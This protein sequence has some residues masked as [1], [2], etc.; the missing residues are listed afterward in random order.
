MKSVIKFAPEEIAFSRGEILRSRGVPDE[1]QFSENIQRIYREADKL[2]R[3]LA[4]PKG[5]IA[6]IGM[7]DFERVFHGE[8]LNQTENPVEDIFRKAGYLALFA[9]TLGSV[10]SSRITD[11]FDNGDYTLGYMLDSISSNAADILSDLAARRYF[12]A[13]IRREGSEDS[14]KV[15]NYSPGYC[16]WDISGQ[17]KLFDYLHPS[18]IGISLNDSYIMTP[19]KSVSGVLIAGP[20]RIHRFVNSYAFCSTC[21]TR[22]C[23]DRIRKLQ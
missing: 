8:G 1:A 19:G 13:I 23:V 4:E 17:R 6:E 18:E 2:F 11:L 12:A 22:S 7:S 5:I 21:T 9:V 3:K 10:L 14:L 20:G 15:L 16:G